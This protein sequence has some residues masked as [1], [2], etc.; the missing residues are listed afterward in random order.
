MAS[1]TCMPDALPLDIKARSP[2]EKLS[3]NILKMSDEILSRSLT[4]EAASTVMKE[5][6]TKDA[7]LF[8][9]KSK[10]GFQ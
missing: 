5:R 7:D 9:A 8:D 1:S 10:N 3:L 2:E 4:I 6:I